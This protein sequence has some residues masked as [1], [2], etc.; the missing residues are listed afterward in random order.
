MSHFLIAAAAAIALIVVA[1]PILAMVL[2]SVASR[3]EESAHT[4]SGRAPGAVTRAARRLL[5]YRAQTSR[6]SWIA[7]SGLRAQPRP[8]ATLPWPTTKLPRP[9]TSLPRRAP[10]NIGQPRP[11]IETISLGLADDTA[12]D[13]RE[14]AGTRAA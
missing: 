9:T 7:D 13:R 2:V 3:H 8:T 4:L 5:S 12:Q 14:P 10:A 6:G 11:V 1:V